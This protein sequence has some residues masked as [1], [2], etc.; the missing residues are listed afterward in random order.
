MGTI[1]VYV[2]QENN[3][4]V[5]QYNSLV[6]NFNKLLEFLNNGGNSTEVGLT[7]EVH[8]RVRMW[9]YGTL[10]FDEYN[11]GLITDIGD[12]ATLMWIFGDSDYNVDDYLDNATYI[13]IGNEGSL[14]SASTQLPGEW[15]RTQGTVEDESQS[16]LNIT[17]TFYPDSSGPYTADCIGLNWENAGDN[18][19]W[20]YDMFTEV[21]GIDETFTINVEFKV[22]VAHT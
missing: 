20:A 9:Q 15:N 18:N 7:A 17:C 21:S 11:S 8:S 2:V 22:S 13:S 4:V 12:N 1:T 5:A 16:W 3:R 19:L 14:S 6:G 10:I